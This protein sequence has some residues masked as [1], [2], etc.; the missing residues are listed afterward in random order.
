MVSRDRKSELLK[1]G[2]TL[3]GL[4]FV[5]VRE[6]E[7]TRLYVHFLNTVPVKEP[8]LDVTIRG[9]DI[10]PE[11]LVEP[12]Q[13]ADWLMDTAG[14]AVLSA[15]VAGGGGV[16]PSRLPRERGGRPGYHSPAR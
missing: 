5:E 13:D 4:D 1:T 7:P 10:T 8:G 9:G 12:I 3:N 11:V 14:R 2:A 16:F 6:S 15:W